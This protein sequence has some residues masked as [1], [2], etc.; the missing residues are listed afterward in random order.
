MATTEL[1]LIRHGETDFNRELRFQGHADVPLNAAGRAQAQA[2]AVR[3]AEEAFDVV[4]T[5][6]LERARATAAPLLQRRPDAI[7]RADEAWREQSFGVLEGLDA[8]TIRARHPALWQAWLRHD[9][10]GAPPGGESNRAF[11]DRVS[12]ALDALAL[13]H[14]GQ[15]VAVVTHGGVLD[16]LWRRL[17]GVAVEGGRSCAIPN[18]GLNR[19][20]WHDGVWTLVCWADDAHLAALKQPQV[21]IPRPQADGA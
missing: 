2:L 18:T 21:T 1:L 12:A 8:A 6:D 11:H 7:T 9:A 14:A 19:L 4:V 16:R 5:S 20:R 17:H 13:A 15:R 3:L 10:D